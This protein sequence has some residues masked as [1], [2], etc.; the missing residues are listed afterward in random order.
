MAKSKLTPEE[1]GKDREMIARLWRNYLSKHKGTLALAVLFMAVLACTQAAYVW[2]VSRIGEFAEGLGA[3]GGAQEGTI[4]FAILLAPL[5]LGLT[6]VSGISMFIQAVLT[7]KVALSTIRDLQVDM[8]KTTQRADFALFARKDGGNLVSRFINDVTILT[9]ALLRTLTNLGRD[10]LTIITVVSVMIYTDIVLTALVL[11]IYPMVLAP[12]IS[13]SRTLRGNSSAAQ[14]QVGIVTSQLTEAFS[15]ARMVKT[16]GLEDMQDNRL[17]KTFTERLNLYLKLVTNQARISPLMEAIG[18]IAIIGV[19][20]AGTWRVLSGAS[21]GWDVAAI[22]GGVIMLAPRFRAL[23]TLN[24]VIQEGLA[25]LSRIF[26]LID[27]Q[28]AIVDAPDAKPLALNGG[29]VT[30]DDVSFTY[31][32]GT[33]AL[34]G[35][36]FTAKAGQTVA[37]VGPS[38]GGKSTIIN[39]LPRLY[40]I[41]GGSVRVDGQDVREVTMKSL[42]E[43]MALVSQDVTLFNDTIRANIAFGK[44][45]ATDE[46]I[47][48]AAKSAAAHDFILGQPKGY[49][50]S[51]GAGGGNLSGGQ[52]QRIAL[53]RA[54]LRDAPIL[55]LDEATSALDAESESKVQAALDTLAENRTTLVIAHRLSTVRRADMIFVLDEGKVVEAGKHDA[56]MAKNGLYAKLRDLQF[57]E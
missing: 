18:G 35:V 11:V 36:T 52:R 19:I 21:T 34:S 7:N 43:A 1:K 54:I 46:E 14:E 56:L 30:F 8:F 13:L 55:L 49:E 16:Y 28:K 33:Q 17:H 29:E 53:A 4:K 12:V 32:D 51:A 50:S 39:L 9:G 22:F 38:G 26:E 57:S 3:A 15:G 42:R 48:A 44:P 31:E 10:V 23:G 20:L 5:V 40:D 24:N 41:A 6:A 25:A 27:E 47:I 2:L 37:L 45:S